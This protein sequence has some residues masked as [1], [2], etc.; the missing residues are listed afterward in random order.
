MA[1]LAIEADVWVEQW[2]VH[3][4]MPDEIWPILMTH[5]LIAHQPS[6]GTSRLFPE[7]QGSHAKALLEAVEVAHNQAVLQ[8]LYLVG[9]F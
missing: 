7:A 8:S 3:V 2:H 1:T 6:W 4:C 5:E 9:L